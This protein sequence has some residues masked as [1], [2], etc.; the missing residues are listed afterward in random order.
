M[1]VTASIGL[2]QHLF[3][4]HVI[5]NIPWSLTNLVQFALEA[6]Y[7]HS[8]Y[9]LVSFLVPFLKQLDGQYYTPQQAGIK[10]QP[11][12]FYIK[13]TYFAFFICYVNFSCLSKIVLRLWD[14]PRFLLGLSLGTCHLTSLVTDIKRIHR[15]MCF[16]SLKTSLSNHHSPL[17][18]ATF[19]IAY[20]IEIS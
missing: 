14:T 1:H 4:W 7:A 5:I 13:R 8:S 15:T 6:F 11:G 9:P 10:L 2:G 12:E 3:L 20:C 16:F 18:H 19:S 17:L